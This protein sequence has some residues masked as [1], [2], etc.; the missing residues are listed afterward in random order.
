MHRTILSIIMIGEVLGMAT[1][2]RNEDNRRN[3][4]R[5]ADCN[6]IVIAQIDG[7]EPIDANTVCATCG[8]TLVAPPFEGG[9]YFDL[10]M[11]VHPR[12]V[13]RRPRR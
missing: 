3:L 13:A 7:R 11:R 1:D 6:A 8:M 10:I 9:N 2:R 5:C 4:A 12:P